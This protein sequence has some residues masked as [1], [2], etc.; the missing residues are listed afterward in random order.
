MAALYT[1]DF[2]QHFGPIVQTYGQSQTTKHQTVD[3]D[4]YIV[5]CIQPVTVNADLLVPLTDTTRCDISSVYRCINDSLSADLTAIFIFYWVI[6]YFCLS[7]GTVGRNRYYMS[8]LEMKADDMEARKVVAKHYLE[9]RGA[10]KARSSVG[11]KDH[12]EKYNLIS[13]NYDTERVNKPNS[14]HYVFYSILAELF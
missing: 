1:L 11:I 13:Q 9:V 6:F 12:P 10:Y 4:K 8:K 3:N 14:P 7:H 2:S 5:L